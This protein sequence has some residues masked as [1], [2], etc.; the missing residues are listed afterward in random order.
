MAAS[1]GAR[2]T[3][4]GGSRRQRGSAAARG[5]IGCPRRWP[6]HPAVEK[7]P[8][9]HLGQHLGSVGAHRRTRQQ[10]IRRRGP[11][12]RFLSAWGLGVSH[13]FANA[14]LGRNAPRSRAG[15]CDESCLA[16][17]FPHSRSRRSAQRG[18]RCGDACRSR[19]SSPAGQTLNQHAVAP[20]TS[21]DTRDTPAHSRT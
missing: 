16:H 10:P 2:F 11:I 7:S 6:P 15:V 19:R 17:A 9:L 21:P 18:R 12:E 5:R 14:W 4:G 3:C 1:L 20:F 13:T 8:E